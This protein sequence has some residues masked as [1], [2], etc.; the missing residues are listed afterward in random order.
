MPR[1]IRWPGLGPG[2]HVAIRDF[3]AAD[4]PAA[5]DSMVVAVRRAVMRLAMFPSCG[6]VVQE[7]VVRLQTDESRAIRTDQRRGAAREP[8][9]GG[10]SA[11]L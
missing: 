6:R 2:D 7:R 10:D 9:P 4:S 11:G 8:P 3:I 1:P 5:A